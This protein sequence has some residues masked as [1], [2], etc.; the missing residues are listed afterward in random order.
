MA[1]HNELGERG[2][3]LATIYLEKRG[4]K[5]RH[6][7]WRYRRWEVDIIAQEGSCLV[8]VEVKTRSSLHWGMPEESVS[9]ER[10]RRLVE[11]AHYYLQMQEEEY[12]ARF[13]V[14]SVFWRG[15][16]EPVLEHFEDA[17]FP[18]IE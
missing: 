15:E 13:D 6:N 5:I 17:F 16:E 12:T 1:K 18:S 7:N 10:M 14:I 9:R 8:F 11:A 4:Y 2:E 3:A